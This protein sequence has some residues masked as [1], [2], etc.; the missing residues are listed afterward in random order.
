MSNSPSR[1]NIAIQN[2]F[3]DHQVKIRPPQHKDDKHTPI[4]APV[5]HPADLN[6]LLIFNA[7]GTLMPTPQTMHAEKIGNFRT[8][9]TFDDDHHLDQPQLE[10][11]PNENSTITLDASQTDPVFGQPVVRLDW[12]MLDQE[13]HT[14]YQGSGLC[15]DYL[16]ARGA[17]GFESQPT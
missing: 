4:L 7:W 12:N 2:F 9:L 16:E 8:M 3:H 14:N 13:K 11:V 17:V 10:Q 6:D 1:V 15:K 5:F